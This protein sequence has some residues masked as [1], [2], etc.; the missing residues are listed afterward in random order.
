MIFA[1]PFT[2][3]HELNLDWVVQQ[4]ARQETE[5][6][7]F[8]ALN[9]IKYANPIQW[10]I[11][12]QYAQNTLV[13]DP[14]DGTAYLS[15]QP[16][17]QGVQIKNTNY[18]TPVFT[19][20]NFIDPIKEA[21]CRSIPQQEDG[22]AATQTIPA[23]SLFFVGN[24]LCTNPAEIPNTSL[25]IV[26]SNCTQISVEEL[27]QPLQQSIAAETAAREQ[28]VSQLSQ[29][30]GAET[31]AREQAVSQLS[32]QF[33]AEVS[34]REQADQQLQQAIDQ[35]QNTAGMAN[36]KD[37]GAVG[38]GVADDTAAVK[39]A[40]NTGR[41]VYIPSGTY[42]ITGNI[43]DISG[44]VVT[45]AGRGKTVLVCQAPFLTGSLYTCTVANMTVKGNAAV[46]TWLESSVIYNIDFEDWTRALD[47]VGYLNAV[48][49][50]CDIN[51]PAT[52]AQEAVRLGYGNTSGNANI[53]F[54]DCLMQGWY[55]ESDED[56]RALYGIHVYRSDALYLDGVD[57]GRFIQNDLLCEGDI[58]Y[59][60]AH[61]SYFDVTSQ[62]DCIKIAQSDKAAYLCIQNSWVASAGYIAGGTSAH[63]V[64]VDNSNATVMVLG[65]R[66]ME[67]R[68]N[69]VR[70]DACSN[71]FVQGCAFYAYYGSAVYAAAPAGTGVHVVGC[72]FYDTHSQAIAEYPDT[73]CDGSLMGCVFI[74]S[75]NIQNAG[76]HV[77]GHGNSPAFTRLSLSATLTGTTGFDT[78]IVDGSGAISDVDGKYPGRQVTLCFATAGCSIPTS[79]G[80][81]LR[82]AF[83]TSN[84]WESITLLYTGDCWTEVSRSAV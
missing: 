78:V 57:L 6:K 8:V 56:V 45:G 2:N 4:I 24:T 76:S 71:V 70:V 43:G 16:V 55:N 36:V 22:Q 27:I 41:G 11:T 17:P 46:L 73:L 62:G 48:I 29:Q 79:D 19:L 65:C 63:G 32:Q 23:N 31:S 83:T 66:I 7:N 59:L 12:A 20:Q 37:Y 39:A 25:V 67:T 34:A 74:N 28:A 15:T 61:N 9:T 14:Q 82:Q 53:T 26:G 49:S 42:K 44:M 58:Q 40:V 33:S 10:D 64:H 21:I 50:T 80:M 13:I 47:I 84:A 75:K 5:L 1:W 54:S 3:L 77:Y 18:W 72:L 30:I 51:N 68:G 81:Q 60:N 69:C 35:L 38:D 52:G